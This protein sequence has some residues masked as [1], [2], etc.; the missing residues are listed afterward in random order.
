MVKSHHVSVLQNALVIIKSSHSTLNTK[1]TA[2]I[3]ELCSNTKVL[4]NSHSSKLSKLCRQLK[5]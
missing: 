5:V 4:M 2:E 1:L 3:L